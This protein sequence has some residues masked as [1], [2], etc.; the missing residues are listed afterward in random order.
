MARDPLDILK[1]QIGNL[2]ADNAVLQSGIEARDEKIAEL[3]KQLPKD[4]EQGVDK[5]K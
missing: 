1:Q 5:E 4:T 3:Q 2:M